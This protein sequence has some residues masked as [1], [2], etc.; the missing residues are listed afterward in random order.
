MKYLGIVFLNYLFVTIFLEN[1]RL[2]WIFPVFLILINEELI[3]FIQ[4]CSYTCIYIFIYISYI[5]QCWKYHLTQ[6][7]VGRGGKWAGWPVGH[8]AWARA[9]HGTSVA[10][11]AG[12]R[13]EPA[14]MCSGRSSRAVFEPMCSGLWPGWSARHG[15]CVYF[16]KI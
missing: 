4:I 8:A 2:I 5:F 9:W 16:L 6:Y 14:P 7:A 11:W 1:S 15:R 13:A 3:Y 10:C 12:S